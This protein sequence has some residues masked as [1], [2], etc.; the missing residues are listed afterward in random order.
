MMRGHFAYY[1][2]GGNAR[3]FVSVAGNGT[4]PTE[5]R[6]HLYPR[7]RDRTVA[8][9]ASPRTFIAVARHDLEHLNMLMIISSLGALIYWTYRMWH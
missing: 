2:V 3:R 8:A 9:T 5:P 6:P 4:A 7:S 1:G